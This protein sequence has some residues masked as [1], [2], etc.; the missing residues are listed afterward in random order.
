MTSKVMC[1]PRTMHRSPAYRKLTGKQIFVLME[2]YRRRIVVPIN[3]KKDYVI[4]N[5]GEIIFTY[6]EAEKKFGIPRSTFK[7]A[8]DQLVNVGFIDIAYQGGGMLQDS[9]KYAISERWREYGKE[10]FK[11]KSRPKDTRKLGFTKNNWEEKTGRKRKL[12][13]KISIS[14]D[15]TSSITN[16]ACDSKKPVSPSITSATHQIAPNYYYI[17]E[18]ELLKARTHLSIANDTIL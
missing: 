3:R 1:V 14:D 15:T 17:K 9:S 16:D 10:E 11:K 2:F 13:S 12:K 4:T 8:I 18:F 6:S 7:R 5:N